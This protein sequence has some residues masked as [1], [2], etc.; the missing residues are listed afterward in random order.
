LAL[1]I[2]SEG[3]MTRSRTRTIRL[4]TFVGFSM[5]GL[6]VVMAAGVVLGMSLSQNGAD[7]RSVANDTP[8]QTAI[9]PLVV[10]VAGSGNEARLLVDRFGELSG[11][12]I[13]LEAESRE[14]A[15]R[16][17]IMQEFESRLSEE[18]ADSEAE[19]RV[20]RTQPGEPSGGPL[21]KLEENE[22]AII[23]P[24]S[25][26]D[27]EDVKVALTRVEHDIAHIAD[28]LNRLDRSIVEMNLS[29]MAFPGRRPVDESHAVTSSFGSRVD[30][31]SR[32]RAFHSGVDYPAPPGSPIYASAGG[33]V[34]FADTR[35]QYGRTVEIDH[36][37]GLV[38]RYAHASELLVE[39]GQI[40]MPGEK[41]AKV[42]STGRSTG[43]HLHFEIL[44]NGRFVDPEIYLAKFE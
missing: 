31:F 33:K 21:I 9:K 23:D 3:A 12:L 6:S 35:R 29:H 43:P 20:A 11:R 24:Q 39:A 14:L 26:A 10:D 40:V 16:V 8:P 30:P 22:R 42:G 37:G 36:G 34:I 32:G 27:D 25:L 4:R 13:Q 28:T 15:S 41:I 18:E 7:T 17:G 19:G 5:L 38:T 1:V 44:K 2:L